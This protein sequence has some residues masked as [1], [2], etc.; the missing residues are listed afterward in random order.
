LNRDSFATELVNYLLLRSC[1]QE[2][3]GGCGVL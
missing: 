3:A 1:G 2:S